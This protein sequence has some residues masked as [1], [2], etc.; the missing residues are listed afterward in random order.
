[1]SSSSANADLG[2]Y[3]YRFLVCGYM[4][5]TSIMFYRVHRQPYASAIKWEQYETIFKGTSLATVVAGA[6]MSSAGRE[7]VYGGLR[8]MYGH[9]LRSCMEAVLVGSH[10]ICNGI[11]LHLWPRSVLKFCS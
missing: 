1:M 4:A 11:N 5:A 3:K 9:I 2:R 7:K 10:L 6:A 8:A